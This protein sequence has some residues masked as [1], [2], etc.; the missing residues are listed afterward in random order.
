MVIVTIGLN[1]PIANYTPNLPLVKY[2]S[3]GKPQRR[4]EKSPQMTRIHRDYRAEQGS[5]EREAG[6]SREKKNV[7]CI[8]SFQIRGVV[9]LKIG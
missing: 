3:W 6:E 7:I 8:C 1:S 9:V 5:R 4:K 2:F